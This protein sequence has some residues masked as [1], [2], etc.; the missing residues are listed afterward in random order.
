VKLNSLK[1]KDRKVFNKFLRIRPHDL[2]VYAWEN[3]FIWK[4]LYDI[5]WAI[6]EDTLCVFFID[7]FGCFQYCSPL[8]RTLSPAV[9]KKC[10]EVMD[11]FNKNKDISRIENIEV[12]EASF[13]QRAG[14]R[15]R[16]KSHDY[17][18]DRQELSGL[19][20][21]KFKSKRACCNY[22]EKNYSFEY[23]PFTLKDKKDC[24]ALYRL[25]MRQR[26][27]KGEGSLYRGMLR[28]S[29]VCL[30]QALESFSDLNLIGR[31]VV[32]DKAL[33]GFT[34]GY[35]L[36]HET[37][38]VL[39]E[40]TDLSVRGLAQFIFREFSREL[41]GYKYLNIMD[42]SGLENLKQVKLSYKPVRLMASFTADR[43]D[44]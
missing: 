19:Q 2:S 44:A 32:V 10:F 34:F 11:L 28:D 16:V 17:L 25:W 6:L 15:C 14:L 5:R 42:D 12:E 3:I 29:E 21:N 22:F 9:L 23:K 24:L 39:F 33:K 4:A 40:V 7:P 27:G 18:C 35:K 31:V 13:Y 30:K 38:C 36:N 8:G 20:G 37:F 26:E 41:E 1:A 43:R